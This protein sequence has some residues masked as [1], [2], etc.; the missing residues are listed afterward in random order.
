MS[1][2]TLNSIC[3][4]KQYFADNQTPYYFISASNFNLMSMQR[5]VKNWQHINLINSYDDQ[6]PNVLV[7][8]DNHEQLFEGIEDINLYLLNQE[9]VEAHIKQQD[10]PG[11]VI[12]LFFDEQIEARCKALGL[13]IVLPKNSLVKE[14]DSKVVT[15]EI[16]N[17]VNV[18]SVPNI[19]SAVSGYAS[20]Q[21]LAKQAG[22]GSSW[23][24]QTPYGDSGKTTFF[25]DSEADYNRHASE[26]EAE[27]KVKVMRKINCVGTAIEACA[28]RWGTFVGPL[29][30]EV[31]GDKTLTPY[32]GGWCGNE[33]YQ[34]A[35]S[36]VIRLQVQQKTER[37]GD[38]LY[39]RG[40]KGYFE[41][42]F[43]IDQETHEVYL[44]ELNA[45]ITGISAMTN[46]SNFSEQNIP[47]FLFHLLEYDQNIELT[48][49][50]DEFN[51]AML[52]QGADGVAAQMILKYTD[53]PL[54]KIVRAPVSGV[55]QL[56][57]DQ[58][59]LKQASYERRE[60]L[61]DN[62]AFIMRISDQGDYA[63]HGGDLAI[64][65]N[66]QTIRN[67]EGKLNHNGQ[68][69]VAALKNTFEYRPLN[70][71]E[72]AA[73]EQQHNPANVKSARETK[74]TKEAVEGV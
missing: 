26:I 7:V 18:P 6:H 40:Y 41:L 73:F 66:N 8:M 11:K 70:Q 49:S 12:F 74:S 69:W 56:I 58:L 55:Y 17:Q 31:I 39:Q 4:I 19:L 22:L 63:Y 52:K 29:L 60:A 30:S 34:D 44:G 20:L 24:I 33:L 48:L 65:F 47:L 51:Q 72:R 68:S 61:A 13:E 38:A 5:W 28:T 9:T 16:G 64:M 50:V 21:K 45:R 62:E 1:K 43:L 27:A 15:T 36:D 67:E 37:I 59:Q 10:M 14:I 3:D 23:V 46:Q 2:Q 53:E 35:F 32:S 57:D 71:E 42:D 25:I 54:K